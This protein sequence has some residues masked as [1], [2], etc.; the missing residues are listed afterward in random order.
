[1]SA[2]VS[3]GQRKPAGTCEVTDDFSFLTPSLWH[4]AAAAVFGVVYA[5][6]DRL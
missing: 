5:N 4:V 6:G 2:R 1:M 3:P